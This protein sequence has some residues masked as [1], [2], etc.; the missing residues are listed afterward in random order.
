M[1]VYFISGIQLLMKVVVEKLVDSGP[2]LVLRLKANLA[3]ILTIN[4]GR[5]TP[6]LLSLVKLGNSPQ[7][8]RGALYALLRSG[9]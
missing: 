4:L 6:P 5:T 3:L 7:Q 2:A 9:A 1:T 8:S